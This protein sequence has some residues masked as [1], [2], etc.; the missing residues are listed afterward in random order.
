MELKRKKKKPPEILETTF[1]FFS[2]IRLCFTRHAA[3][4]TVGKTIIFF[5][6]NKMKE[7]NQRSSIYLVFCIVSV[8][9]SSFSFISATERWATKQPKLV[10]L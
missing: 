8:N 1:F 5:K 7:S 6:K 4:S 10:L 9:R 3:Q 2:P